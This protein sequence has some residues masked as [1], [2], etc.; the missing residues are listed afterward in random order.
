VDETDSPVAERQ[1]VFGHRERT[2]IYWGL[3]RSSYRMSCNRQLAISQPAM[4]NRDQSANR[5][6]SVNTNPFG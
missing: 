4:W 3:R 2:A 6:E 5:F 1:K